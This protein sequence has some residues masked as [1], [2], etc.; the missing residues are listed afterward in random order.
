MF[1]PLTAQQFIVTLV[2]SQRKRGVFLSY[3]DYQII[4]RWLHRC[5]DLDFLILLLA[6]MLP[7]LFER[8]PR[9]S[10]RSI[11]R[12]IMTKITRH[13]INQGGLH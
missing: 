12:T 6:D 13:A 8:N 3:D 11:D 5:P 7:G 9:A 10:L 4:Q 2:V 1:S